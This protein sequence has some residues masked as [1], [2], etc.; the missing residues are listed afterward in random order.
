LKHLSKLINSQ[1]VQ[2]GLPKA[3][4]NF[5]TFWRNLSNVEPTQSF[6]EQWVNLIFLDEESAINSKSLEIITTKTSVFVIG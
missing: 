5:K 3:T 4:E 1:V 6:V 2:N